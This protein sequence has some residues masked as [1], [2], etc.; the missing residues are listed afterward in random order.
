MYVSGQTCS[1]MVLIEMAATSVCSLIVLFQKCLLVFPLCYVVYR[2]LVFLYFLSKV[3][4]YMKEEGLVS[5]SLNKRPS[6]CSQ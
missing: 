5:R 2:C 4:N 3:W 6:H 1:N